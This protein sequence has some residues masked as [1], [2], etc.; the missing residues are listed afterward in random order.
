MKTRSIVKLIVTSFFLLTLTGC[1]GVN[2]QFSEVKNKIMGELGDEYKTEFQFSVGPALIH[3]SSL[4]V[5]LAAEEEYIDDMLREISSVQ[6]GVYNRIEGSTYKASLTTLNSIDEEMSSNGW[7]FIV[8][9]IDR[10]EL[11]TIYISADLEELLQKMYIINLND[12][13][14]VIVEVNGDLKKVISYAIEE[15]SFDLKM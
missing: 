4:F 7:K 3:V 9:T 12:E 15:K 13:E 5:N 2:R 6:V 11:T 14:L 10:N 8:R 1:I